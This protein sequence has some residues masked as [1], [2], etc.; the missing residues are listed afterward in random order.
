MTTAVVLAAGKA[1][2]MGEPKLLMPLAGKAA[3]TWVLSAALGACDQAVVVVGGWRIQMETFL[4]GLPQ[5][6]RIHAVYN[7]HYEQGMFTSVKA[8]A[9]AEAESSALL[10][11]PGDVPLIHRSTA[12]AVLESV[13]GGGAWIG[14]PE[15]GGRRG[16]PVA[17]A[18]RLIQ[19]LLKEPD[20]GTLR[21]FLDRYSA[22]T[23][24]VPVQ[25]RDMLMDMDTPEEYERCCAAADVLSKKQEV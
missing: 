17:L 5:K 3:L 2:R 11:F 21:L 16:H 15:T 23:A 19:E 12:M 22:R 4:A 20:D 9:G 7:P 10:I 6:E 24:L 13:T 1:E 18:G 14:I 25:D 8:G